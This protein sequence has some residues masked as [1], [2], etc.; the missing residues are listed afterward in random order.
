MNRLISLIKYVAVKILA[1]YMPYTLKGKNIAPGI[2]YRKNCTSFEKVIFLLN[3]TRY[4]HLGDQYFWAPAII[5][6]IDSKYDVKILLPGDMDEFWYCNGVENSQ[7][8]S[9]DTEKTLYIT[10]API[11]LSP[12]FKDRSYIAVDLGDARINNRVSVHLY[13][14]ICKILEI[15]RDSIPQLKLPH[16]IDKRLEEQINQLGDNVW[17]MSDSVS[18]C[19]WRF[20]YFKRKKIWSATEE[21]VRSGEKIVYVHE[22]NGYYHPFE[23]DE[24]LIALDLRKSTSPGD[25]MTI[26]QMPNIAGTI[27]FDNFLM[28]TALLCGKRARVAFRGRYSKRARKHCFNNVN[29]AFANVEIKQIEYL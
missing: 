9:N 15:E 20:P 8:I 5:A 12:S 26:L 1:R 27:S 6:A 25:I 11:V 3:D 10:D 13:N 7:S 19:L 22:E 29:T 16:K 17:L 21:I 23:G 24:N 28:H 4:I 14:E 18:S 2:I